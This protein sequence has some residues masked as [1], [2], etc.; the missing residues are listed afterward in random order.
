M[1]KILPVI[2]RS[3]VIHRSWLRTTR[4]WRCLGKCGEERHNT[5]RVRYLSA[6]A[7][8]LGGP[9]CSEGKSCEAFMAV[10]AL[11]AGS[12]WIGTSHPIL[13]MGIPNGTRP[14]ALW[15]RLR[16]SLIHPPR[17]MRSLPG[18]EEVTRRASL[19]STSSAEDWGQHVPAP[20]AS[21]IPKC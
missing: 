8:A 14:E 21:L 16:G 9:S 5:N 4:N 7:P 2:L 3:D 6:S 18:R 13:F 11:L 12:T 20:P 1:E 17:P 10:Q 15:M 19:C